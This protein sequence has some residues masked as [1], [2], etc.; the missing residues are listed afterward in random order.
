MGVETVLAACKTLS[1]GITGI[2]KAYDETP[3]A[4]EVT[5]SVVWEAEPDF[6]S[7]RV[8]NGKRD[9][10]HHLK[11]TLLI[12][13]GAQ[14]HLAQRAGRPFTQLF[15]DLFDTKI[16]LNGTALNSA[17]SRGE[18]GVVTIADRSFLAVTFDM[19]AVERQNVTYTG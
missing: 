18:Y 2:K 12:G 4:V 13:L 10:T 11:A 3:E 16:T 9:V 15:L 8:A 14:V 5:P 1:A 6:E 7:V 17:I 19:F